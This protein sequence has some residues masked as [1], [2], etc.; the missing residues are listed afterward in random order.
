M[1]CPI[2]GQAHLHKA[3]NVLPIAIPGRYRF[4]LHREDGSPPPQP[5]GS[6]FDG[7]IASL[8]ESLRGART[9]LDDVRRKLDAAG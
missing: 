5:T 8:R 9:D 7:A 3:R 6:A 2:D 4:V 1:H